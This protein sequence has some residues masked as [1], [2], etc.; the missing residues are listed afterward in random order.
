M[1]D[2][3]PLPNSPLPNKRLKW[4]D[5][6]DSDRSSIQD[7]Y[8]RG[9]NITYE[10]LENAKHVDEVPNGYILYR[11]S[12]NLKMDFG[13]IGEE[14]NSIGIVCGMGAFCAIG[15]PQSAVKQTIEEVKDLAERDLQQ[16]MEK[17]NENN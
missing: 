10:I 2:W 9:L 6:K 3:C 15:A 14:D 8:L 16:L 4:N 1:P 17:N 7:S 11:W 12:E 5:V 13:I